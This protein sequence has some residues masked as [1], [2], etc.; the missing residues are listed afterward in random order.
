MQKKGKIIAITS[1]KGGTGKTTTVL[2]IAG[3][4]HN[5]RKK[6]IIIDLDLTSG[7][8]SPILNIASSQNICTAA[9]DIEN[10]RYEDIE[11]Y[12]QKYNDYI[13]IIPSSIDPRIALTIN[14]K[15]IE[16]IISDL[17]YQY[18]YILIDTTHAIN[19]V[20]VT[21]FDICDYIL[22]IMSDDL[23][24]IKNMKTMISIFNNID[25]NKYK[26]ILN[27]ALVSSIGNY[28]ISSALGK[29]I[30]YIIPKGA[31]EKKIQKYNYNGQ[32]IAI[33]KPRIGRIYEGLVDKVIK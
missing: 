8:I 3:A 5:K 24:D 12:I 27:Q 18:E 33:E 17:V 19:G 7:V 30:D 29:A 16:K 11:K 15:Y 1:V 14:P 13:S 31:Y 9:E 22:Y 26:I 28:E 4:L 10:G 23:M 6:T 21:I 25:S 2:N 32:I 20:N